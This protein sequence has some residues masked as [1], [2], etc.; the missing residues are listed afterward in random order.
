MSRIRALIALCLALIGCARS[1][2]VFEADF[3][4]RRALAGW[5]GDAGQRAPGRRGSA[6][7]IENADEKSSTSRR[8][9][10]PAEELAG[11][12]VTVTATVPI[13]STSFAATTTL[14]IETSTSLPWSV[15]FDLRAR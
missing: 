12:L 1:P 2:V 10:L 9:E 6:L 5:H 15:T 11:K 7:L 13:S 14:R 3:E 4:G 8:I